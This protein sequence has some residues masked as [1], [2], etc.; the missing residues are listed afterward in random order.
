MLCLTRRVGE[1]LVINDDITV[2][3]LS[4]DRGQ[5]KVGI[6]APK[7]VS[8]DREEIYLKKIQENSNDRHRHS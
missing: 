3:V 8:I 2:I 5:V 6:D 7:N 1:K 4:V